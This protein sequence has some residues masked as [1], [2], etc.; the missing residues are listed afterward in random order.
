MDFLYSGPGMI[1]M[2]L[3]LVGLIFFYLRIQKKA[4]DDD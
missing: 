4:R 1:L 3:L 2:A